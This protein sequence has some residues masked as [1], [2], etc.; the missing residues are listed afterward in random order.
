MAAAFP[1]DAMPTDEGICSICIQPLRDP[2]KLTCN[3]AFCR[4]CLE[5]VQLT[6]NS[7][8]R[9]HSDCPMCNCEFSI[10]GSGIDA[11]P[12]G[13]LNLL[14]G[15]DAHDEEE[16]QNGLEKCQLNLAGVHNGSSHRP[17]DA[18]ADGR[19]ADYL[20]KDCVKYMCGG[21]VCA[22]VRTCTS[23]EHYI[24]SLADDD[25]GGS[26]GGRPT[27]LLPSRGFAV[28]SSG[29]SSSSR[30]RA[31]TCAAHDGEVLRLYCETCAA[32]ICG[33]CTVSTHGGHSF[34]YLQDAVAEASAAAAR[35]VADAAGGARAIEDGARGAAMMA[36]RV[37]ARAQAAAAEVR[38]IVRRHV[39][40][41][42]ERERDLLC[43]IE[44]VR[45][46]KGRS[47][48]AQLGS[49][50]AQLAHVARASD[51]ARRALAD[52]DEVDVLAARDAIAAAVKR[53][54]ALAA[55]LQ[56]HEDDAIAFTPP[57][58]A[59]YNAVSSLGTVSSGA[60]APNALASGEGLRS[61]LRGKV[62]TFVVHAKDHYGDARAMG[63]DPIN[64][65][66]EAPDASVYSGDV[67]DQHNGSYVITYCP[68]M[69]GAH[70]VHVT[71]RGN[72]IH[73]S[74][75]AV[76][77][78]SGRTYASVGQDAFQFGEE[79]DQDGQ[80]CRP[81][82]ICTDK[83][84]HV[85]VAD[86]SNNRIQVFHPDG[87]FLHKFGSPG[88]HSGQ[89]DRPAGVACNLNNHIVVADK[90]NHRVQLFTLTGMFIAKFGER[91]SKNGQF[92][93]P[94]DVA[95]N[96]NGQILVSDTRNHRIQLFS[97][98]GAFINKYGFE[99]ALWKH[100]DSP[101]GVTFNRDGHVIVT[102]F[103]NHRLLVIQPDFQ[104]ARFLGQEGSANGQ[105]MR[106]QG[107][108]VDQ[109]GNMIVADSRNHRIQIFQPSGNF[110]C[111]FGNNGTALGQMD[112]PSGVCV[113][114]DGRIVVVDFGNSRIQVL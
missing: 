77:V 100:F 82:G 67:C 104:S 109:E 2:E 92:N 4:Q 22:H 110:L 89:F 43:R 16:L 79:G 73:G 55:H 65:L 52:G 30:R 21:C 105:F 27:D 88:T 23:K 12:S 15:V 80:L 37:E 98:D 106:P 53:V 46:V 10:G 36:D 97:A 17:C 76:S 1:S 114:P 103:N 87:K 50:R 42:V 69:E 24:V 5:R 34:V 83:Y 66:C 113:T 29:S 32:A 102:D 94:W 7:G 108:A 93:Y 59:L 8:S 74:P 64:V 81:W 91:G 71:I 20:C 47:L 26:S 72:H 61:A 40:A 70:R 84:G 101:R 90:D 75:F 54:K 33:D 99:G 85:V 56:P 111:K 44:R 51:D 14:H 13:F 35:L 3:H 78:R 11:L 19:G 9:S 68:P 112:R 57:D 45:Q 63:G 49:L 25:G 96:T 41:L 62:A 60:Y 18:C 38:A 6:S 48:R 107:V 86:R 28:E 39:A 31:R 58:A 95:V